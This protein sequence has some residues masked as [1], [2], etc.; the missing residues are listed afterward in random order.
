MSFDSKANQTIAMKVSRRT[1][2]VNLLLSLFKMA[3]GVLA[4]SSAMISDAV[5]SASDVLSTLV[6][7][8]GIKLANRQ[9]DADHEYGHERLECIAALL[10]AAVLAITG[11]GIGYSGYQKIVAATAGT[12]ASPGLL[13]IVA[14]VLSILVKEGMYWYTRAAALKIHSS[15]LLADAWHHRSDALSSIGSFVGILGA[16]LGWPVLDPVASLVI[17]FFIFKVSYDIARQSI[18][19]LT[20]RS[21]SPALEAEMRDAILQQEGVAKIDLL[22]TRQFGPRVYVDVEFSADGSLSLY[23]S[24]SIAENVHH[25]I[26]SQFPEV[27]HCMVHVNPLEQ[28]S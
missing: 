22:R 13:A 1:I 21:C 3:A 28:K 25:V 12:L 26:E 7:M 20:D 9:S 23:D 8:V 15:A 19:Q 18:R 14:A 16:R 27:K 4:H 11:A 24:H 17:C 2:W 10:L 6:V 5:H